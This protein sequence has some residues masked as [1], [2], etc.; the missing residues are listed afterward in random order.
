MFVNIF[1]S[2]SCPIFR[3]SMVIPF[4]ASCRVAI[5]ILNDLFSKSLPVF[6][7]YIR[8]V[9]L[10][11]LSEIRTTKCCFSMLSMRRVMLGLSLKVALHSSCWVMPS[12][13][14]S[15]RRMVHCSGVISTPSCLKFRLSFRLIAVE[16]FPFNMANT[17]C[18][19]ILKSSVIY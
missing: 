5:A 6:V 16:T 7:R 17:S 1:L 19:S 14:Q 10:S 3:S 18:W 13:S 2:T 15:A 9:R 11:F 8:L 12:F 4:N